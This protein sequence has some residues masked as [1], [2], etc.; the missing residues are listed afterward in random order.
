MWN[1]SSE[2]Q[3]VVILF[4]RNAF[5]NKSI[6]VLLPETSLHEYFSIIRYVLLN[7][8]CDTAWLYVMLFHEIH[9][10]LIPP[11]TWKKYQ[12]AYFLDVFYRPYTFSTLDKTF[13]MLEKKSAW[14]SSVLRFVTTFLRIRVI[15]L[16][17]KMDKTGRSHFSVYC[18]SL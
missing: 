4:E 8:G 18:Q 9:F 1:C 3:A 5:L 6:D 12:L 17:D 11:L 15:I 7:V 14:I 13:F 2:C 16:Y 10:F